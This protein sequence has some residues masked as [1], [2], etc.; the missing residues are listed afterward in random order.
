MNLSLT[1]YY[2]IYRA[3]YCRTQVMRKM[4]KCLLTTL[5]NIKTQKEIIKA[6]EVVDSEVQKANEAIEKAENEVI[7][8]M[9]VEESFEVK[10]L[11]EI[12]QMKAGKFVKASGIYPENGKSLYPCYGG[13]GLRGYVKTFTHEGTYPIIGRQ[14]AL[15]GNVTFVSN[16]FH[17]TEHAVVV[18]PIIEL[19]IK[20]LYHKLVIM[21]LNQYA[22]GVAQ[23]GLS[24]KNIEPLEIALP[25]LKTQKEIVSKVQKLEEK[26]TKAKTIVESASEKKQ[27]ILKEYL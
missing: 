1:V 8:I 12:C 21:N 22:T 4:I 5:A 14:G 17:A 19:D 27:A 24:V 3:I 16:K 10:K 23:P 18:T 20:W 6:C 26:I 11:G 15:C 2:P 9:D 25:P 7:S 13:N